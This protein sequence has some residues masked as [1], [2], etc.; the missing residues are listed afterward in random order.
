MSLLVIRDLAR[1]IHTGRT[2]VRPVDG[3][4]LE[5]APREMVGLVGESGSGKSMTGKSVM[6][7]LPAGGRVVS[8]SV[9]LD[10]RELTQLS[11]S[12]SCERSAAPR[13]AWSSRTR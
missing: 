7:L 12:E 1:E 9:T 3:V 13:S 5:V 8:G 4:S 10:G 2:V 6:G 11:A